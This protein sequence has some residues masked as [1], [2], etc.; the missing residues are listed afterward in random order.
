M[1]ALSTRLG[2]P[3]IG[4]DGTWAVKH[5]TPRNSDN[6]RLNKL[7]NL[8]FVNS[9]TSHLR[10]P[11]TNVRQ[12]LRATISRESWEWIFRS[13]S[14]WVSV[15]SRFFFFSNCSGVENRMNFLHHQAVLRLRKPLNVWKFSFFHH[16]IFSNFPRWLTKIIKKELSTLPGGFGDWEK[17]FY[18][19]KFSFFTP[20]YFP[21]F[22]DG[23][24]KL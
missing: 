16:I 1:L 21:I 18:G 6:S 5:L 20:L 13:Q 9:H 12:G 4:A 3:P 17:R 2:L 19:W 14:G 8:T 15:S 23:W 11:L 24:Q 7:E 22:Q 10:T